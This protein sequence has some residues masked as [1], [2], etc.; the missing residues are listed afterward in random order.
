MAALTD[1]DK[2]K[3]KLAHAMT[4]TGTDASSSGV[5]TQT[6]TNTDMSG[7][8]GLTNVITTSRMFFTEFLGC[9]ICL[10]YEYD[11]TE[12]LWQI[13]DVDTGHIQLLDKIL[14]EH[15][16]DE[17]CDLINRDIEERKDMMR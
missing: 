2:F 6:G 13:I 9:E 16:S 5:I 17:I 12:I 1:Q 10:A 7:L 14:H 4:R 8:N 3:R 15:Y 11:D